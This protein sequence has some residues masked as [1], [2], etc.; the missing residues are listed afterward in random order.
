MKG[1]R[2]QGSGFRSQ[3]KNFNILAGQIL[4]NPAKVAFY[5]KC[6]PTTK[7]IIEMVEKRPVL[8]KVKEGENFNHRYTFSIPRIEI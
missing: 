1:F 6:F 5:N 4:N 2:V 7:S 8:F 3:V